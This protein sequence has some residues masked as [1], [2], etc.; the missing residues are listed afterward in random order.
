MEYIQIN[1]SKWKSKILNG[2]VIKWSKRLHWVR[3]L[4]IL[5]YARVRRIIVLLN[6]LKLV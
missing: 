4:R 2:S 1:Q 3:K 5:I 6:P